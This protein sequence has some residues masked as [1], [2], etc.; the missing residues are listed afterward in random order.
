MIKNEK[1]TEEC[2]DGNMSDLDGCSNECKL[3]ENQKSENYEE[4]I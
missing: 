3:E 4:L 1:F 2:D